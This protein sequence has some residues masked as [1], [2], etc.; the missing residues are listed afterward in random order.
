M[1]YAL[2]KAIHIVAV[3]AWI[4]GMLQMSFLL[5]AI[6]ADPASWMNSD[7]GVLR[8][9]YVWNRRITTPAILLAWAMGL[10]MAWMGGWYTAPWFMAKFA[11]AFLLAA[12]HGFQSG[13]LRRVASDPK[14]PAPPWLR[15]VTAAILAAVALVAVLVAVKPF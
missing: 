7:R 9:A 4:A 12:L 2:I 8:A 14:V 13:A 3:I 1:L 6:P 11:I 15:K 10:V 5:A